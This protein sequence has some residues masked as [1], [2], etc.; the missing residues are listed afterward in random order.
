M[1]RP[2]F[3]IPRRAPSAQAQVSGT[4]IVMVEIGDQPTWWEVDAGGSRRLPAAPEI[5]LKTVWRAAAYDKALALGRLTGAKLRRIVTQE[6]GER[7][8]AFRDGAI[9]YCTP[10]NQTLC[11]SARQTAPI[12]A[13]LARHRA[14]TDQ[15]LPITMVLRL[16]DPAEGIACAWTIGLDGSPSGF[17]ATVIFDEAGVRDAGLESANAAGVPDAGA[18]LVLD[19]ATLYA[20]LTTRQLPHYPIPNTWGGIPTAIWRAGTLAATGF[21]AASTIAGAVWSS[22]DL[23]EAK[24]R[25]HSAQRAENALAPEEHFDR[26][27]LVGLAR[28]ASI[29]YGH[30]MQAAQHLA[31]PGALITLH[32]GPRVTQAHGPEDRPQRAVLM[33]HARMHHIRGQ[34]IGATGS[35]PN[36]ALAQI[37]TARA[38]HGFVLQ[39]ILVNPH[40]TRYVARYVH[41]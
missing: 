5:P 40:G 6:L 9:T 39:K 1:K 35:W 22:A 41:H 29:T 10:E 32:A 20:L 16:G 21:L 26:N 4:A 38:P 14:T 19:H 30:D 11:G 13:V 8:V 18:P 36:R 27:H 28:V 7:G 24:T 3:K 15:P 25:W 37:L 31:L 12:G 34:E 17:T 33:V 23:H 2:S